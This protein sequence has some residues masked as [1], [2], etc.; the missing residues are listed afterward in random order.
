MSLLLSQVG[1]PPVAPIITPDRTYPKLAPTDSGTIEIRG[2]IR[3]GLVVTVAAVVVSFVPFLRPAQLDQPAT[4]QGRIS[5]GYSVTTAPP[6]PTPALRLTPA[7]L[8]DTATL[9]GRIWTGYVVTPPNPVP[10]PPPGKAPF[11]R[12]PLTRIPS[13]R[14]DDDDETL[15]LLLTS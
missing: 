10:P 12:L 8:T 7:T 6:T 9:S 13:D 3:T 15:I 1:P 2:L 5:T 14:F 4:P 11:G